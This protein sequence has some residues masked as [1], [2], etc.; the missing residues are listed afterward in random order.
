M[1]KLFHAVYNLLN[2]HIMNILKIRYILKGTVKN[3]CPAVIDHS[4]SCYRIL[5]CISV[6]GKKINANHSVINRKHV[7]V[8]LS[9]NLKFY[10]VCSI[11]T[12]LKFLKN[13]LMS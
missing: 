1:Y 6:K 2:I 11:I 12:S 5:L 9:E 10:Y 3:L 7:A 4:Q 13:T 8:N